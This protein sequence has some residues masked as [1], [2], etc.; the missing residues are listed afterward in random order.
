M[1]QRPARPF[2]GSHAD[3]QRRNVGDRMDMTNKRTCEPA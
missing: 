3:R 1:T 2:W